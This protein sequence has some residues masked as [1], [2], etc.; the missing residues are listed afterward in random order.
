MQTKSSKYVECLVVSRENSCVFITYT[1]TKSHQIYTPTR[2]GCINRQ[3]FP[4]SDQTAVVPKPP[5]LQCACYVVMC[6]SK[7]CI[8]CVNAVS[9]SS[10]MSTKPKKYDC[11][12]KQ[13]PALCSKLISW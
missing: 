6:N 3:W 11:V 7:L 12:G 4:F 13:T 8:R 2:N 9:E 1:T 10:R 5:I